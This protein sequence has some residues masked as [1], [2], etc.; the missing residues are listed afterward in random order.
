M[1]RTIRLPWVFFNAARRINSALLILTYFCTFLLCTGHSQA[2]AAVDQTVTGTVSDDKGEAL[3]GVSVVVKGTQRGTNTDAKGQYRITVPDGKAVLIFSFV[4]Y[5]P[6]EMEVGNQSAISITL[7]ADTKSLEEVVV[8]GYGTQKKVNLTGAVDQ[9]TSEVL[10]NRSLPNLTQGL[11]G[12]IPN[13]NLRMGDGKPTQSPSYNIRGTTSIGQ[14]GNALV[15]IDGVEGDPSRLNPNDVASVSVLKDAASAAI[16]GARGAFGVVLIT[17]KSPTKD[18]TSVTYSMNHSIKSP[19]TVPDLVTN[20]YEFAK[21]FNEG[22]TAWNDYSQTPQNVNK[23]VRF[24]PAYL[25]EFERR[26]N[27]PSLPKTVV[28]PTTGEYVYYENTDW[29]STLR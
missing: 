11:Q 5:L 18:R 19:T 27:D 7:K 16:Y 21:M 20:G 22:W 26:N 6:Q 9:V 13:L 14:G 12:T 8:V 2:V 3:P 25:T 23:T 28:D 24:S 29:Y 10:E 15:L 1:K 17:T 4:G